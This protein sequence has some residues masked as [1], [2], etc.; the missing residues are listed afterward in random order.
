MFDLKAIRKARGITQ[1]QLADEAHC[2]RTAIANIECGIAQ[3]SVALAKAL[4]KPLGIEWWKFFE[5]DDVNGT[6]PLHGAGSCETPE[7]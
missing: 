3:P 4:A 5:E 6:D 1:Q 2:V 7:N